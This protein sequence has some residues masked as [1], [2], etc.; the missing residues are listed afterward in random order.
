MVMGDLMPKFA[1]F[2][3]KTTAGIDGSAVYKGK[4][5]SISIDEERGRV[6]IHDGNMF[7]FTT[8]KEIRQYGTIE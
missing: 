2:H 8:L 5:Y 6:R 1:K 7:L 4:I 3:C